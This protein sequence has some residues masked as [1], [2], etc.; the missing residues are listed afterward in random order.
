MAYKKLLLIG[1]FMFFI[2]CST[3]AQIQNQS[4]LPNQQT[5]TITSD[6]LR[7]IGYALMLPAAAVGLIIGLLI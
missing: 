2:G 5:K 6:E 1:L 4:S 7:G 3:T